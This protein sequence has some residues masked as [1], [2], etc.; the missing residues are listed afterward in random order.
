[1]KPLQKRNENV[2]KFYKDVV[3]RFGNVTKR[4]ENAEKHYNGGIK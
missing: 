1:M 3:E 4:R 2:M